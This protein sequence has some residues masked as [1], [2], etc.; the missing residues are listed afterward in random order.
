M[1]QV[2]NIR[3]A[4]LHYLNILCSDIVGLIKFPED[5]WYSQ[6]THPKKRRQLYTV[7]CRII[8][9][10]QTQEIEG[11]PSRKVPWIC[12][13]KTCE[14]YFSEQLMNPDRGEYEYTYGE[15]LV[16]QLPIIIEKLKKGYTNNAQ[17][18]I[19]RP[20]D[21][22]LSDRPCLQTI[23]FKR[24]PA[25]MLDMSL[26]FR[27]WDIF[28][29]PSNLIGLSYVFEHICVETNLNMAAMYIYSSGLNIRKDML[30]T[31]KDVVKYLQS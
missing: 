25:S 11:V 1:L 22:M 8:Y 26:Y 9:P 5:A 19:A 10:Q 27:S 14:D 6:E 16:P 29:L 13:L 20:D 2:N 31:G 12:S 21:H 30:Q 4:F 3:E 28:A 7:A 23:D 18:V 15:R 24:L 17:A